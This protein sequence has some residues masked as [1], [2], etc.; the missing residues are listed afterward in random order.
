MLPLSYVIFLPYG[1]LFF[2]M[3]VISTLYSLSA[4]HWLGAWAGLEI[5]LIAFI[6]IILYQGKILETESAIK[7]FIFQA[8]GSAL[9]MFS[10]LLSFGS[11]F[12]WE[13]S[14]NNS[15]FFI[16]KG[17]FILVM[18]L[19]LKLGVFPFHFWFPSVVAG[20]SWFSSFLLLTW[21]KVAPLFLLFLIS[22]LWSTE[23][24]LFLL[25][26]AG[27]SSIIG[28]VGGI[29]QTQMRALLAYSSISHLGWMVYCCVL[30]EASMKIYFGIYF[31]I[32]M[33]IFSVIWNTEMTLVSQAFSSFFGQH[34]PA[35]LCLIAFFLSLSG[36]PPLLG[37]APKWMV[38][39]LGSNMDTF[40][41]L[42]MLVL[43]SLFSL[44]YYL[45]LIFSA[46]FSSGSVF[47]KSFFFFYGTNKMDTFLIIG[48]MLNLFGGIVFLNNFY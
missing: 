37:F 20:L 4:S 19:L 8:V 17:I 43:G 40:F 24:M 47:V 15:S 5:N 25:L 35:R 26:I 38:L 3:M 21:Q 33:C 6:P 14:I 45:S 48:M 30:S 46:F 39:N 36:I 1:F 2:F 29:N 16:L 13:L 22:C 11:D 31:L 32:S 12:T 42:M 23:M 44:F 27:G 34:T 28:G 10:S 7:Y 18:G 41:I 9:I